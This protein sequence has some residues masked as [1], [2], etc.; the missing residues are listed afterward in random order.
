LYPKVQRPKSVRFYRMSWSTVNREPGLESDDIHIWTYLALREGAEDV[1]GHLV[2]VYE[3][4]PAF[5]VK[6]YVALRSPLS[7][8]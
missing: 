4:K 2:C 5:V 3:L 1:S 7:E 6:P 8:A